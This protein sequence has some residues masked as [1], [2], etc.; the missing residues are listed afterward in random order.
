MRR[1]TSSIKIAELLRVWLA[2]VGPPT[3]GG[4][5]DAR[6]VE[7]LASR[8]LAP[9]FAS[10]T[11]I[12]VR[13]EDLIEVEYGKGGGFTPTFAERTE[14]KPN[15]GTTAQ[16]ALHLGDQPNPRGLRIFKSYGNVSHKE[17]SNPTGHP[18]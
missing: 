14:M 11:T 12:G 10:V 5:V 4:R 8:K 15:A 13:A 6:Q 16:Q 1:K 3:L 2:D 9:T 18:I 7:M 17:L